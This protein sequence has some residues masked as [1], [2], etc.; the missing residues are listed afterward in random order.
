MSPFNL[1]APKPNRPFIKISPNLSMAL[2]SAITFPPWAFVIPPF[3]FPPTCQMIL[4]PIH[5]LTPCVEDLTS[6]LRYSVLQLFGFKSLSLGSLIQIHPEL[7]TGDCPQNQTME[8]KHNRPQ[9][10]PNI[11]PMHPEHTH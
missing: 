3:C 1:L 6:V 8:T 4:F 2:D 5:Y 11:Y 9:T 10:E 7:Q